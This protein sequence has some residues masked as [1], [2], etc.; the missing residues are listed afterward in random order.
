[1]ICH[2]IDCDQFLALIPNNACDILV[3]ILFELRFDERLSVANRKHSLDIDLREGI[4]HEDSHIPPLNGAKE[5]KKQSSIN[6]SLLMERR[7]SLSAHRAAEPKAK[8]LVAG[9]EEGGQNQKEPAALD[10]Y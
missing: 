2:A 3:E 7:A 4:R 9:Q 8:N 10:C 5:I 1:M 6:I